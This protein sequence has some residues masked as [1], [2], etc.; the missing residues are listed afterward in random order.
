[1]ARLAVLLLAICRAVYCWVFFIMSLFMIN[2]VYSNVRSMLQSHIAT[3]GII[4]SIVMMAAYSIVFVITWWMFVRGKP[5]L[6]QWA[7][8]ANLICI[9]AYF[10]AAVV[11]WNWR[12]F[13]RAELGMRHVILIGIFGIII[14]SIPYHGWR[15]K[16]QIPVTGVLSL[17]T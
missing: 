5:A 15:H 4:L 16:S 10:P 12:G 8:A 6:K 9:L 3:I 14:F 7:I 2:Y 11:Y 1:M 13:L 17:K